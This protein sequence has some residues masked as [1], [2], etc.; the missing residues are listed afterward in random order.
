MMKL[1][2]H[3]LRGVLHWSE[4]HA[5]LRSSGSLNILHGGDLDNVGWT[6]D[7]GVLVAKLTG[8]PLQ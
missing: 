6:I 7:E 3:D 1:K 4:M 2:P 5:S 8:S